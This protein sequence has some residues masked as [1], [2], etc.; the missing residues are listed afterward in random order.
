MP[1]QL[2]LSWEMSPALGRGDF[3]VAEGNRAAVG[4]IDSWPNWQGPAAI[5]GPAGAGKSHL[6]TAWAAASQ[7]K[8][9]T[10]VAL[11]LDTVSQ[12]DAREAIAQCPRAALTEI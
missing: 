10:A 11:N 9:L 7:A 3:I 2:T 8:I 12:L 5:H 1:S 4:L 6:V